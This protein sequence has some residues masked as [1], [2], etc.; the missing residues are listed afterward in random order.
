MEPQTFT[1]TLK[2]PRIVS[3]SVVA[4]ATV[5]ASLAYTGA[6]GGLSAKFTPFAKRDTVKEPAASAAQKL[7][8]KDENNNGIPDWQELKTPDTTLLGADATTADSSA[9]PTRD[10]LA[11]K[12]TKTEL[13]AGD[14]FGVYLDRKEQNVYTDKDNEAIIANALSGL[15]ISNIPRYTRESITLIDAPGDS[16]AARYRDQV[17]PIV[18]SLDAIGEYELETY[19]RAT[20]KNTVEEFKKVS[21]AADVYATA[22][23]SLKKVRVPTGAAEAHL[24]LMNSFAKLSIALLEMSKGYND[25][26]G[27]YAALKTFGEAEKDVELAYTLHRTYLA[28]HNAINI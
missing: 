4:L 2:N 7:S 28:I 19:A 5:V 6:L 13:L 8:E 24:A 23:E 1:E 22:V 26:A 11:K 9:Q 16:A 21:D 18:K 17:T 20:Q 15:D 3:V 14:L 12:Y 25:I 10:E 27:S